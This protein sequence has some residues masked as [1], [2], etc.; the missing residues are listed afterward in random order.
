MAAVTVDRI[1]ES[2]NL[3]TKHSL[4]FLYRR[5]R[6][7][8]EW[9]HSRRILCIFLPSFPSSSFP[10]CRISSYHYFDLFSFHIEKYL[11]HCAL[12]VG[13]VCACK[14]VKVCVSVWEQKYKNKNKIELVDS[15]S[16]VSVAATYDD[17]CVIFSLLPYFSLCQMYLCVCVCVPARSLQI[18]GIEFHLK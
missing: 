8:I 10:S 9:I 3:H 5:I 4:W 12:W 11:S 2:Q 1:K 16:A 13:S 7:Y 6:L 18:N 17:D 15:T 14:S